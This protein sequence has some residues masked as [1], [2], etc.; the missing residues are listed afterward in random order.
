MGE[1]ETLHYDHFPEYY[2]VQGTDLN[3]MISGL[4]P[5]FFLVERFYNFLK[6]S[7]NIL[8]PVLKLPF[9]LHNLSIKYGS[10]FRFYYYGL[11]FLAKNEFSHDN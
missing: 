6:S 7:F 3:F 8:Y 2:T 1:A 10:N 4:S 5:C 11:Y 9:K